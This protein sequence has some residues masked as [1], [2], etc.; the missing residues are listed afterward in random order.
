MWIFVHDF[1]RTYHG[2]SQLW[3]NQGNFSRDF[4]FFINECNAES[5][6]MIVPE[7]L[8]K[9]TGQLISWP[10]Y[11]PVDPCIYIYMTFR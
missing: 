2:H 3:E 5:L 8:R 4:L 10:G 6:S 1:T 9:S 7:K 11:G